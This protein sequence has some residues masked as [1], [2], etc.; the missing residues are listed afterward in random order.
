[1][2]LLQSVADVLPMPR[3]GVAQRDLGPQLQSVATMRIGAGY[4][5]N[6]SSFI[7]DAWCV[8]SLLL[9]SITS[10][11]WPKV[12]RMN[13]QTCKRFATRITQKRRTRWMAEDGDDETG[14]V[15]IFTVWE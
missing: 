14:P 1:M 4:A 9:M 12:A 6:T 2:R 13:G 5:R 15:E 8:V 10:S 3:C 11:R 7:L